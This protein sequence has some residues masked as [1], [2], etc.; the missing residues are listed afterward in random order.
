MEVN[1]PQKV[2]SVQSH[3]VHG[4]VGNRCAVF[5]LQLLGFEVDF[6]NTVQFSNH[7]GYPSFTGNKLGRE[8]LE[9]LIQ[10]LDANSL[11]TYSLL[12]TGYI[13]SVPFL[14][15]ITKMLQLLRERNPNIKYLC[16][17]VLGDN[18]KLYV[19]EE[20]VPLYRELIK[21]AD[22]ITPNQFEAQQL[23]GRTI[24]TLSDAVAICNAF[25]EQGIP[26]VVITSLTLADNP[27]Q[28]LVL[29][30]ERGKQ[31]FTLSVPQL[32]RQFTGTG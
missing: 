14:E 12:L 3:V 2:L 18:G 28:L 25:H 9:S 17:P 19:P 29:G 15:S 13:G 27:G 32:H 1:E 4:Y 21:H 20:M 23:S 6:I 30:S 7:T 22:T 24:N 16:D 11:T 31:Q 8:D 10:G 26:R 5:P